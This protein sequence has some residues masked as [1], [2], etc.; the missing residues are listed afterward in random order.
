MISIVAKISMGLRDKATP[1]LTTPLIRFNMSC[2]IQLHGQPEPFGSCIILQ[3]C[4]SFFFGLHGQPELFA[5]EHLL[6]SWVS[7]QLIVVTSLQSFES[8]QAL[9][10]VVLIFASYPQP[11]FPL[12]SVTEALF[13][14]SLF[15]SECFFFVMLKLL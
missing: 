8:G 2:A 15:L 14:L 10:L 1:T 11:F 6:Q 13:A 4:S 12:S 7:L 3:S 5:S 9:F